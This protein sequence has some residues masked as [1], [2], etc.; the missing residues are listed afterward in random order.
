MNLSVIALLVVLHCDI[1]RYLQCYYMIA[2][3]ILLTFGIPQPNSIIIK[4]LEVKY[5]PLA[6]HTIMCTLLLCKQLLIT[7]LPMEN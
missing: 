7:N 1:R 2:Q 3:A 5:C 4:Q 6:L